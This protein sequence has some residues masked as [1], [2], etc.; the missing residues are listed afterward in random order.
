MRQQLPDDLVGVDAVRLGL[1][2]HE[3]AVAKVRDDMPLRR[4]AFKDSD[5]RKLLTLLR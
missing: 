1:E 3:H 4:N 2:V 5:V